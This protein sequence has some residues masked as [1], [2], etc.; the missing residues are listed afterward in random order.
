MSDVINIDKV[1]NMLQE[2]A[3]DLVGRVL[4]QIEAAIPAENQCKAV[5]FVLKKVI[6]DSFNNIMQKIQETRIEGEEK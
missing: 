2:G 5:K 1:T 6:Y 4:T 3:E